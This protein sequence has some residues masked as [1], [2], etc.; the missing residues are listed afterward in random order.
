MMKSTRTLHTSGHGAMD[1][2]A[3]NMREKRWH[4]KWF[5]DIH[6]DGLPQIIYNAAATTVKIVAVQANERLI[7]LD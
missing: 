1:M 4:F 6:T 7:L 3:E 2:V 5:Q